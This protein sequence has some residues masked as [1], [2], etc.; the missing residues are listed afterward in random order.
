MTRDWRIPRA[1]KTLLAICAVAGPVYWLVFTPDGQRRTDLALMS[2]LGRPAFDAALDRFGPRIGE[3]D[4]RA[5]FP[6]LDIHCAATPNPFGD[7]LC[8]AVLGSF[9][10]YPARALSLYFRG[11]TLTAVKVIYQGAYHAQ[12]RAWVERRPG[13]LPEGTVP[14][15]P[16]LDGAV[17]SWPVAEGLLVMKDGPL[18]DSDEPTLFWLAARR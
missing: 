9:N 17:A 13:R 2:V 18:R 3:P 15:K 6:A 1:Y 10:G 5:R 14:A 11:E 7:R 8:T 16:R 12:I 4:L